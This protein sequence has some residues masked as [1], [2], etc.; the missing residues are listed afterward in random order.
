MRAI[1]NLTFEAGEK[2]EGLFEVP[3]TGF[4]LPATIISG[5]KPGKTVLLTAGVHSCEYVGI[6]VLQEMRRELSPDDIAGTLVIIPV[7][8][9]TGFENRTPTIVPED[10]KNL[11]RVFPGK[12]NGFASEK[13]AW[14]MTSQLFSEIDFYVDLH[15]GGIFED[16]D[17]Y[18]Y[19]VGACDEK[20][21][22]Y[23]RGAAEYC[24]VP[25]MVKS[26]SKTGCYNWAGCMGVPSLLLE[27]GGRGRWSHEEVREDK[28]DVVNI[29]KYVGM[30]DGEPQKPE[31]TP[32]LLEA[33]QYLE[34]EKS[35]FYQY[36]VD[37]TLGIWPQNAAGVPFSTDS[38]QSTGDPIAD[39]HEDMAAEQKARLTY[40]N[41]LR[42]CK[43]NPDV[44]DA[45][46]FLR[47]REMVHY[48]RFGESLRLIQDQ[49]DAKNFYAF[50]SAFDKKATCL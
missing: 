49:L 43:D 5:K 45:I 30:M 7:V 27:R 36:Y 34:I 31:N 2:K 38:I 37:H 15:C 42:L 22:A 26:F 8:N 24:N 18:V 11:T 41:I 3:G 17:R 46:K 10:G 1:A 20:V 47:A 33:P 12:A 14:F 44:Y 6:Q 9:R 39:L 4:K 23:A 35:G 50:N 21:S 48:Q 28:A 40:D 16:L 19:F 25:Y 13:L 29:L 32:F